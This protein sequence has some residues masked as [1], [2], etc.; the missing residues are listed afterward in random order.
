MEEARK[1]ESVNHIRQTALQR[2]QLQDRSAR[3]KDGVEEE[4]EERNSEATMK[5]RAEGM[6]QL[7]DRSGVHYE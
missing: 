5:E 7:E 3:H 2:Q 1:G 6:G 4:G